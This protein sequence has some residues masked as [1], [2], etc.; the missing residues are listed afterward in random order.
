M[1]FTAEELM[2]MQDEAEKELA[3]SLE[4]DPKIDAS[5][6]EDTKVDDKK[7]GEDGKAK[8]EEGKDTSD[9]K[10]DVDTKKEEVKKEE[11]KVDSKKEELQD[12]EEVRELR[13]ITRSQKAELDKITKEYERLNKL[14]ESKGLVDEDDK[15][16]RSD[17]ENA[18]RVS[19]EKRLGYLGDM[20]EIMKVNP[21][22]EDV[23]T[24]VSQRHFDDMITALA[25]YHVSQKGGDI[26]Q[27]MS[28]VEREIWSLANP[29]SYMYAMV[30]KY[31]PDYVKSEDEPVAKQKDE[32]VDDK[33]SVDEKKSEEK[34]EDVKEDKKPKEQ[35]MSLQDLPGGGGKDGGGWTSAK[36]DAMD[37]DEL[38]KVPKDIYEKYLKNDLP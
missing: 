20:L 15:K 17:E 21:R 18:A 12:D 27:V 6:K 19:Y 29:Y 10:G 8:G 34:K 24:V 31:H 33:K 28:E 38:S 1:A 5:V 7:E 9:A 2:T 32:K 35:A 25:K 4:V 30:K 26:T 3:D 11:V 37:E 16:L 14:L 36:I 13:T 23:E 22:Y